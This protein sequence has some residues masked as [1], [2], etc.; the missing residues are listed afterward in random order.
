MGLGLAIKFALKADPPLPLTGPLVDVLLA[1]IDQKLSAQLDEILRHE[2]FRA[3]ERVWRSL[4]F[5]VSRVDFAENIQVEFLNLSKKDLLDD[6]LDSPE[7]SG[8]GLY[9]LAYVAEYGQFGG[10]PLAALVTDYALSDSFDDLRLLSRAAELG[11]AI[12][13]P[14][15]LAASPAFLGLQSFA[16]LD[17]IA[18]VSSIF[19][20]KSLARYG[21]LRAE[22][23]S[24]Y[25]ALLWPGFLL[26]APYRPL[27]VKSFNYEETALNPKTDYLWGSAAFPLAAAMADSFAKYRWS[28]NITGEGGGGLVTGLPTAPMASLGPKAQRLSL[29]YLASENLEFALAEEGLITLV[30]KKEPGEA[31]FY[32]AASVLKPKIF[33]TGQSGTKASL[34]HLLS[35]QLPYLMLINRLA[36]YLKVLQRER[37]G[38]FKS[39]ADLES[40]LNQWLNRLVTD[41]DNPEPL[42]R[43]RHPLRRGKATV[44]ED[45][46]RPGWRRVGLTVRPHFKRLGASFDLSLTGRLEKLDW[47]S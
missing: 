6:F 16:E 1:E 23:N 8:S 47:G 15:L 40:E 39:A 32:S 33:S 5:L 4:A 31:V 37:L 21:A 45:P 30:A 35:T 43:G 26:R 2:T 3:L 36:H 9:R 20:R 14:F 13:A 29:E 34:D 19:R 41:M 10:Q 38:S 28:V 12:H 44:E 42:A 25:L 46:D 18:E 27:M 24:R 17:Q 7:I 11:A 22:E